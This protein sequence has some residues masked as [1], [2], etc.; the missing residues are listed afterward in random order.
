MI[1]FFLLLGVPLMLM[2]H[3]SIETR[4]HDL[5]RAIEQA[6]LAPQLYL[7]RGQLYA[8]HGDESRAKKDFESAQALNDNAQVQVALGHH[9]L[10][11]GDYQQ[12]ND[13]FA[14]AIRMNSSEA[15]AWLG[16]AKAA[17]E[18][19]LHDLVLLSYRTYF[20]LEANPQPG[21]FAAAVRAI[22]PY[23]RTAAQHLLEEGIERLGPV[24]TLMELTASLEIRR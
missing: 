15:R 24:P 19:G 18:L 12:A 23:D 10:S 4:I 11:S 2:A 6:P 17:A 1:R 3:P 14:Q 9:F 8:S 13:S 7:M 16:Q 22:A 5:D 20:A 21:Y